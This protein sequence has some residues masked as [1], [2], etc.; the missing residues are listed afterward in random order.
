MSRINAAETAQLEELMRSA[1]A[2]LLE[3]WPGGDRPASRTLGAEKKGDGSFVTQADFASNEIL[4][5]G[6]T[7]LFPDDAILSEEIPPSPELSSRERVWI[8]DPLD[9][10]KSFMDGNDDFSV[11]V[12]RCSG[13]TP[14][15]GGMFFPARKQFATASLGAGATLNGTKLRV[16]DESKL[17][18]RSVYVRHLKP[19][20]E[21]VVYDRWL[22]SGCA[23]LTLSEGRFDG[24]IIKIVSHREWDLAAPA[25]VIQESGGTVT[26]ELGKPIAFNEGAMNYK[27]FVASNGKTHDELLALIH[28]GE[29]E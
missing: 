18:P 27:Y 21:E 20:R 17:R 11:L 7:T 13:R 5:S 23:F 8:I 22:D 26:D 24:V 1:G 12:A 16:S 10:T 19:K 15:W 29:R 2:K 3:F 9:G 14:D 4:I 28:D 6:L 25:V